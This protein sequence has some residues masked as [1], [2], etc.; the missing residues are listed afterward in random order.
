[1]REVFAFAQLGPQHPIERVLALQLP[2]VLRIRRELEDPQLGPDL[3]MMRQPHIAAVGGAQGP[4][5]HEAL[6][7]GHGLAFGEVERSRRHRPRGNPLHRAFEAIADLGHRH[8]ALRCRLAQGLAQL[9]NGVGEHVVHGRASVPDAL[10]QLLLG[11]DLVDVVEQFGQQ[12]QGPRLDVH[13]LAGARQHGAGGIEIN[14]VE[15]VS[16]A[17]PINGGA[18]GGAHGF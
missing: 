18:S 1:M 12:A 10:E 17:G 4:V 7:A 2:Q 16:K 9:G 15:S 14:V 6:A 3:L 5:Q 11:H 8:D 13:G